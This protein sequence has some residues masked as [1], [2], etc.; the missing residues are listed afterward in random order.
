MI[1]HALHPLD[2]LLAEIG[3]LV[4]R[5]RHGSLDEAEFALRVGR[6]RQAIVAADLDRDG[7]LR[8]RLDLLVRATEDQSLT[9]D[10]FDQIMGSLRDR[11]AFARDGLKPDPRRLGENRAGRRYGGLTVFDGGRCHTPQDHERSL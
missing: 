3:A 10:W 9:R 11:V 7:R 1:V 8:D 2:A 4:R 5:G 6:I